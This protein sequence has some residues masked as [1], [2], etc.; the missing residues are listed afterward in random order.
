MRRQWSKVIWSDEAYIHLGD[1]CG[2]IFITRRADEVFF[3]GMSHTHLQAIAYM[4]D[5]VGMHYGGE[6]GATSHA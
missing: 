3:G 4:R 5:G 6:E 1:D 2:R